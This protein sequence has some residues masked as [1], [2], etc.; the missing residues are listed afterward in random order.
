M[1]KFLLGI[2]YWPRTSAMSM[3][4]RFDL[5]EI[6]EDFARIAALGLS[7]V[8]FFLRW[9]AFAPSLETIDP[10]MLDRFEAVLA[11]AQ[12]YGLTTMPTLFSG[13][14]SGVNW[15][16]EWTLDRH[17]PPNRFRSY[18]GEREVP[19]GIGD[20]YVG[21]LLD[22]QRRLARALGERGR[23]HPAILAW[24]LGNEFS[25]LR[26]PTSEKD[27]AQWSQ[28]LTNDLR[29]TSRHEVTGG[30]HGE[31]VTRENILRPSSICEPWS[32]ATMH[33]YSVY[34]DFARNRLDADVVPFLAA[35]TRRF[36]GKRVLFSEFGNPTC[37]PGSIPGSDRV[38]LPG[39]ESPSSASRSE[40]SSARSDF[41]PYACLT[42]EEMVVYARQVLHHLHARGALGAFWWCWTDYADVLRENPPFDRA[43]HELSFGIIRS[44]GSEKPIA[45][46]L[47]AFAVMRQNILD[48]DNGKNVIFDEAPYYKGFPNSVA[49]AYSAYCAYHLSKK[50]NKTDPSRIPSRDRTA[51]S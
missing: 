26:Q 34:S 35:V 36:S 37:P 43:P 15:L 6:D 45:R 16:P 31:D 12:R 20:F 49:Q 1:K 4:T 22:A 21:P 30:I 39:E 9:D 10:L 41:A 46:E 17:S 28:T 44:D 48:T 42:E 3:W 33:G 2:N 25:N 38:P 14:M 29:E 40:D 23:E 32:F 27:A 11:S 47:A 19:Y 50:I 7:T 5:G 51:L 13:H 18:V 8:R 24:D